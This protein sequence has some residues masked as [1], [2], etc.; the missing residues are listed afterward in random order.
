M[1]LRLF[2]WLLLRIVLA[3]QARI[4]ISRLCVIVP[5]TYT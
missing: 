1:K 2:A 4:D 3:F 5:D